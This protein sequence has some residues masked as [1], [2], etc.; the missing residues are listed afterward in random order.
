MTPWL[1]ILGTQLPLSEFQ[2][3]DLSAEDITPSP[4]GDIVSPGVCNTHLQPQQAL[5]TDQPLSP[6]P[7]LKAGQ[8]A[9]LRNTL[10]VSADQGLRVASVSGLGGTLEQQKCSPA[11]EWKVLAQRPREDQLCLGH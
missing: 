2:F 5:R 11:G 10:L 4:I 8:L 9:P 6:I 7:T 1:Y 3:P